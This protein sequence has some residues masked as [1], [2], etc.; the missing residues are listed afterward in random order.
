[1]MR[2][3]KLSALEIH[4]AEYAVSRGYLDWLTIIPWGMYSKECHDLSKA[5]KILGA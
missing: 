3:D 2:L 5:E 1:M 4:S